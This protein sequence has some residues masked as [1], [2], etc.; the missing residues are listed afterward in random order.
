M[1]RRVSR[2]IPPPDGNVS[3]ARLVGEV[4]GGLFVIALALICVVATVVAVTIVC[5]WAADVLFGALS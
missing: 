2:P 5:R 4:L 3:I 1:K